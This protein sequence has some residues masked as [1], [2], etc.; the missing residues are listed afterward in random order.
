[1]DSLEASSTEF[2]SR[3]LPCAAMFPDF[4]S[5]ANQTP[6]EPN[7]ELTRAQNVS[8]LA[9]QR[10]KADCIFQ[11]SGVAF[12]DLLGPPRFSGIYR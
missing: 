9:F 10:T 12:N 3:H 1:M 2:R 8:A 7:I 4:D 5:E 6:R 11:R